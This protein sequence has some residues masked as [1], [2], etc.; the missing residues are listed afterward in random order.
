MRIWMKYIDYSELV[1]YN[2]HI[3]FKVSAK[4][5]TVF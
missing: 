5:I 1:C 3:S 4:E 2:K